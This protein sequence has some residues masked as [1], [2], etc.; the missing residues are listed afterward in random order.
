MTRKCE[1]RGFNA[2]EYFDADHSVTLKISR[3]DDCV[4]VELAD[5]EADS[6]YKFD[7]PFEAENKSEVP[8]SFVTLSDQRRKEQEF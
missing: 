2:G 4:T 6:V 5:I 1:I 7:I 3:S 8:F